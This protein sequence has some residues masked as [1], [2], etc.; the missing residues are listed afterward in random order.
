MVKTFTSDK[1][2]MTFPSD[3][4]MSLPSFPV[5]D[6]MY[7]LPPHTPHTVPSPLLPHDHMYPL[8]P[9]TPHTVPSPLLPHKD[10]LTTLLLSALA[11]N[12]A[13]IRAVTIATIAGLLDLDNFLEPK[14]VRTLVMLLVRMMF[15]F[16]HREC[17]CLSRPAAFECWAPEDSC[18]Q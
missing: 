12:H 6:H 17:L 2:G 5:H 10:T 7:P 13:S 14:E 3:G 16:Y 11:D 18:P 9:H 8:P 15:L 1:E 4:K